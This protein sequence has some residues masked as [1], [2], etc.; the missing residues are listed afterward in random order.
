[1]IRRIH[2]RDWHS[3]V[4]AWALACVAIGAV[5]GF[6]TADEMRAARDAGLSTAWLT[7]ALGACVA[8]ILAGCA[9]A[10]VLARR[11]S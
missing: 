11:A 5:I 6:A 8:L 4:S 3:L 10:I 2:P 1:M 9:G 7:A